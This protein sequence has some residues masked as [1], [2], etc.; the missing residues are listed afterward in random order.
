M[1]YSPV[2]A[3]KCLMTELYRCTDLQVLVSNKHLRI[4]GFSQSG[5]AFLNL[6][7]TGA[8]TPLFNNLQNV[9]ILREKNLWCDTQ[10]FG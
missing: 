4:K 7:V 5:T 3:A 9:I 6:A 2:I 10:T 8:Y 1:D